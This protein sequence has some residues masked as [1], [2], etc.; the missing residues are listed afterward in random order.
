MKLKLRSSTMSPHQRDGEYEPC[1]C[2]P[3]CFYFKGWLKK[4]A[5]AETN[6][7]KKNFLNRSPSWKKRYVVLL[8]ETEDNHDVAVLAVFDKD[9]ACN[10]HKPRAS[11]KLS[12][13]YRVDKKYDPTGKQHVFE[14]R[15]SKSTWR[16]LAD[17][18]TVMDLWVFY[19]QIQTELRTN[20]PGR[21]FEVTPDDSESMRRIGARASTCLLHLSK[22]GLTLALKRTRSLVGQWPLKSI[23]EFESSETGRFS[24]KAGRSSPMGAAEYVFATVPGQDGEIYDLLDTYTTED[25]SAQPQNQSGPAVAEVVNQ[26]Y[27]RLRLATFGLLPRRGSVGRP[28]SPNHTQHSQAVPVPGRIKNYDRLDRSRDGSNRRIDRS[29]SDNVK[30]TQAAPPVPARTPSL[31]MKTSRPPSAASSANAEPD[32]NLP[33]ADMGG[34][35]ADEE[36]LPY[37][38]MAAGSAVNTLT[39]QGLGRDSKDRMSWDVPIPRTLTQSTAASDR[40]SYQFME[41]TPQSYRNTLTDSYEN[42]P[43]IA[44]SPAARGL[45]N[46]GFVN[47]PLQNTMKELNI[48]DHEYHMVET[49]KGATGGDGSGPP[50][51]LVHTYFEGEFAGSKGS[52][53]EREH[54]YQGV[55]YEGIGRE[56]AHPYSRSLSRSFSL[57]NIRSPTSITDSYIDRS[58]NLGSLDLAFFSSTNM[59]NWMSDRQLPSLPRD[60]VPPTEEN[61]YVTSPKKSR[62]AYEEVNNIFPPTPAQGAQQTEYESVSNTSAEEINVQNHVM[63]NS[64]F[65]EGYVDSNLAAVRPTDSFHPNTATIVMQESANVAH[66]SAIVEPSVTYTQ[67]VA[68]VPAAELEP[69]ERRKSFKERTLERVKMKKAKSLVNLSDTAR[70]QGTKSV[71]L[72]DLDNKRLFNSL[73]RP[74]KMKK[75]QSNPNLLSEPDPSA[76][77]AAPH[78][79]SPKKDSDKQSPVTG[80]RRKFGLG[81]KMMRQKSRSQDEEGGENAGKPK[82]LPKSTVKKIDVKGISTTDKTKSYTR[83][84]QGQL[85]DLPLDSAVDAK[86]KQ[87]KDKGATGKRQRAVSAGSAV[88]VQAMLNEQT[89]STGMIANPLAYS[90][91]SIGGSS[92]GPELDEQ[93]YLSPTEIG[94]PVKRISDPLEADMSDRP[95]PERPLPSPPSHSQSAPLMKVR[96]AKVTQVWEL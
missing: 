71:A 70:P 85:S 78:F 77:E 50:S 51:P 18:Q 23:R 2:Y 66:H 26:D 57:E 45:S 53:G 79:I 88:S 82:V 5:E 8:K 72:E 86:I 40:S 44:A 94:S 58:P 55:D 13:W 60:E 73:G 69:K 84:S 47:S 49:T 56:G 3:N 32:Y 33:Y 80:V 35:P 61:P 63:R 52:S 39:R 27:E 89:N 17:S 83:R 20:F 10:F 6:A 43:L 11:L 4:A 46:G 29:K 54:Q 38:E 14:V 64:T 65:S 30:K 75:S 19:L 91:Q 76:P 67:V 87:A 34:R 90:S 22:W 93:G 16:F 37:T 62:Y 12:P 96:N 41:Y 25:L 42:T 31:P 7:K 68:T 9:V 28:I 74:K 36:N 1:N 21:C 81:L 95:L 48:Q 15:T 92:E 59:P 24:F